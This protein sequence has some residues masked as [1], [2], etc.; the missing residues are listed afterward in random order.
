MTEL[1]TKTLLVKC[2]LDDGDL[3]DRAKPRP[4]AVGGVKRV[5]VRPGQNAAFEALFAALQA[6][7]RAVTPGTVFYDLFRSRTDPQ[8]YFVLEK[9]ENSTAWEAHQQSEHGKAYFPQIRAILDDIAVEY[10]D[11]IGDPVA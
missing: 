6:R 4:Q 9:Y 5:K 1:V 10:F 7:V 3:L 11:E 2:P 8:G